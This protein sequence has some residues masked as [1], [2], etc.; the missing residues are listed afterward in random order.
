MRVPQDDVGF[1]VDF[2]NYS[3][4]SRDLGW[5]RLSVDEA[6]AWGATGYYPTQVVRFFRN[7]PRIRYRGRIHEL[8]EPSIQSAGG[9]MVPANVTIHHQAYLA[10]LVEWDDVWYAYRDGRILP[11][12]AERER[13]YMLLE[14]A[15]RTSDDSATILE[16]SRSVARSAKF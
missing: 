6:A 4:D 12:N 7:D 11:A 1:I 15:R 14:A 9:R 13:L 8:V 16:R 3:D 2:R 5:Q 10:R